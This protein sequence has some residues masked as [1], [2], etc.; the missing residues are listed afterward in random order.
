MIVACIVA[1]A[2]NRVI[3]RDGGLPW[4]LPADLKRF[5]RATTGHPIIMGRRTW[6]SI[7]RPLPGRTSIVVTRRPDY[8]VPEGVLIAG[9]LSEA[10]AAAAEAEGSGTVYVIGGATLYAEALPRADRLLLTLVHDS[11]AGDVDFPPL[12]E[13]DW[14]LVEEE[15]R[16]ADEKN[17]HDLTFL[18]YERAPVSSR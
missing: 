15:E 1:M 17:A 3:G 14:T 16:P 12:D 5:R 9:S 10:L 2:A 13:Q 7:G 8:E 6:E 18:T 4:R 11:P